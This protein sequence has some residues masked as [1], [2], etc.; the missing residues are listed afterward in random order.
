[1]GQ[2]ADTYGHK[3]PGNLIKPQDWNGLIDGIEKNDADLDQ[4]VK[5]LTETT[6]TQ[7]NQMAQQIAQLEAQLTQLSAA[8]APLLKQYR[9]TLQTSKAGFAIGELAELVAHVTDVQGNQLP[10]PV[11]VDFVATWGQFKPV[12]GFNSLGGVGDRTISVQTDAQGV[13]RVQIQSEHVEAFDNGIEEEVAASLKTNLPTVN[14]SIADIILQA[15]TPMEAKTAGAF[16][17]MSSEY[18][19]ADAASVRNYV[20]AYYVKYARTITDK[21]VLPIH[22]VR[23]RDYRSTVMVVAKNDSDPST[24]DPNSGVS[25]IQITFRDWIGPWLVLEYANLEDK[26]NLVQVAGARI[27]PKVTANYL[28][29]LGL[30]KDEIKSMVRSEGVVGKLR[31][32]QV[33]NTALDQVNVAQPPPFL[34]TLTKS[35]QDAISIQQTLE[36]TQTTAIGSNGSAV[37]FEVFTQA[38]TRADTNVAGLKSDLNTFVQ[39]QMTQAQQTLQ[40][41]VQQQQQTFRDQLLADGGPVKSL[42]ESQVRPV[43]QQ[44]EGFQKLDPNVVADKI[45]RIGLIETALN[46]KINNQ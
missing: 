2:L 6:T 17:T 1:M 20:D 34:N 16:K 35:V 41:Q 37:A 9:V 38:A 26:A 40:N 3:A 31:D 46:L 23:W 10:A 39:Q 19:R 15:E 28:E 4:R 13:A 27:A 42:I 24:P 18:D 33:I 11:W 5:A 29:S 22:R 45:N 8:V 7:L 30:V 44:V 12:S 32:Y 21:R 25:S 43:R 36:T 14:K